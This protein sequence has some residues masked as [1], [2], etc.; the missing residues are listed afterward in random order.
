M[1]QWI[2]EF[3]KYLG[4]STKIK[5]DLVY[6]QDLSEL[7]LDW[8]DK[9]VLI[10]TADT[11][12]AHLANYGGYSNIVLYNPKVWDTCSVQ[13]MS[14]DSPLGF[15]RYNKLQIPVVLSGDT[16]HIISRD[17]VRLIDIL[18]HLQKD[19]LVKKEWFFS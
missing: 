7:Y 1:R 10:I 15:C 12:I 4:I 8:A 19:K 13:S 3:F 16:E 2:N 9:C 5:I 6:Y 17:I 11:S 18:F 14:S